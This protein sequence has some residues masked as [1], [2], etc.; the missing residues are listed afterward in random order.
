MEQL[1]YKHNIIKYTLLEDAVKELKRDNLS[2]PIILLDLGVGRANDVNK[3][4][5][6]GISTIIGIDSNHEQLL[7]AKKRTSKDDN[8]ILLE[9]NLSCK[10][11]INKLKDKLSF[12]SFDIICANF[13]VHYF[14]NN[15]S[16]I[17]ENITIKHDCKFIS[18]FM[19]LKQCLF[20]IDP[21][22]EN[23]Y[24]YIKKH[25]NT[26]I[27]VKFNDTPYFNNSFIS[28]EMPIDQTMITY[29]IKNFFK[30]VEFRS[31]VDY[32]NDINTLSSELLIIELMHMTLVASNI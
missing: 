23:E 12:Y 11:D 32:Y 3:W 19:S 25:S 24:V 22:F 13:S 9:A 17:F 15:L 8:V 6:L 20:L 4:R 27:S 21:Y 18:T 30:N 29:N 10:K 1:R 16:C 14:I 2:R 31:F 5:R 26:E 28:S 7:E